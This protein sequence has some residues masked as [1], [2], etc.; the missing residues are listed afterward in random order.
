MLIKKDLKPLR[1]RAHL[2]I[3]TIHGDE[4]KYVQEAFDTNWVTAAGNN[5]TEAEKLACSATGAGFAVGLSTGTAALHMCMKLAGEK[6]SR[7]SNCPENRDGRCGSLFGQR[8]FASDMTFAATVNPALYEGAEIVFID[9]ER[10]TWN[11]DPRALEAAFARY[12][13][14]RVV[15]VA[16]LY[17]TPAK[18]DEISAICAGYGAILIEDAAESLGASCKGKQTGSYGAYNAISFNGNK[19]I[20]GSCGGMLLTEDETAACK[21][22]KWSTQAREQ[23]AWYQHNEVGYNYRMSNIT[24]GI[25]RAQFSHLQEH[26]ARKKQIYS[27]YREG[28]SDLPVAMNPYPV[29]DMEPNFWLS[30]MTVNENAMCSQTRTPLEASFIPEHGKSCPTEILKALSAINA[31]G[32]PIWKPM[33][34]QPVF[35]RCECITAVKEGNADSAGVAGADYLRK[36]GM[37]GVSCAGGD[38]CTDTKTDPQNDS[39]CTTVGADIFRRGLC[40]P[41]AVTMTDEQQDAII[42]VIHDCFM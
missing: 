14:T 39:I 6:I 40:L 31:E 20:T 42:A 37:A 35:A 4:M 23:A 29:G 13:E 2:S 25:V 9:S 1:E 21:V 41:S 26:I 15:I 30:C 3:A 22:R 12:P 33:S 8:V 10:D 24:A 19:I 17:G 27:K 34:M 7:N 16:N 38:A 36:S 11:M 5:I 32:R 28:L 18:L